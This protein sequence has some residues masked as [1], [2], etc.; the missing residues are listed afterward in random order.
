MATRYTYYEAATPSHPNKSGVNRITWEDNGS[1]DQNDWVEITREYC[2]VDPRTKP[3][4][5]LAAL[6]QA[7]PEEIQEIKNIIGL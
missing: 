4:P 7:T 3:S 1:E 5:A 6:Q 2:P